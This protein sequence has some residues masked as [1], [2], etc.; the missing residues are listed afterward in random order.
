MLESVRIN[1]Q[2]ELRNVDF[3]HQPEPVRNAINKWVEEHT[4]NKIRDLLAPGTI[5]TDTLLVLANAIY[6]KGLWESQFK[7]ELTK[8]A[9]FFLQHGKEITVPR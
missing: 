8:E 7:K 3:Q 4:K 2:G 6:F 9:S 5:S 1:F